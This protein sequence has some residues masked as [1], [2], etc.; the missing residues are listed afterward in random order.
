MSFV[1]IKILIEVLDD[2]LTFKTDVEETLNM[3]LE[4]RS[5]G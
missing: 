5:K 2:L 3:N 1:K 4:F